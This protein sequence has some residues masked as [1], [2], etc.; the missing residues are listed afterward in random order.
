[1]GEHYK[2]GNHCQ[3][4][5]GEDVSLYREGNLKTC[6]AVLH[7]PST[8]SKLKFFKPMKLAGVYWRGDHA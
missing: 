7:V 6:A 4:P 3:H 8:G 1:L 5:A 2:A